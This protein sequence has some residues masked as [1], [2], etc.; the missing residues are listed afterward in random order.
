[1]IKDGKIGPEEMNAAIGHLTTGTGIYAGA[2]SNLAQSSGGMWSGMMTRPRRR[3]WLAVSQAVISAT[4]L[5][6]IA[7]ALRPFLRS[8]VQ[9]VTK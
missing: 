9:Q 6:A 3:L 4:T 5:C 8:C 2:M 1:M 7:G